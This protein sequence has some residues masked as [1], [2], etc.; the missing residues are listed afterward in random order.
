MNLYD[1]TWICLVCAGKNPNLFL[2]LYDPIMERC[3]KMC[4]AV[5]KAALDGLP[6]NKRRN[7]K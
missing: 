3:G 6:E 1:F 4:S 7:K 5:E 2:S